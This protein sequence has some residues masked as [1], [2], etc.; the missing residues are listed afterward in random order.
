[1]AQ[2]LFVMILQSKHGPGKSNLGTLH[3]IVTTVGSQSSSYSKAAS[4]TVNYLC[5]FNHNT[6]FVPPFG[7]LLFVNSMRQRVAIIERRLKRYS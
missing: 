1:M 3:E 2:N 6:T 4:S 7:I 5:D